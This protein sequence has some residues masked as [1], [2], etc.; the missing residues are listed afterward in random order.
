MDDDLAA[1]RYPSTPDAETSSFT[2]DFGGAPIPIFLNRT[3]SVM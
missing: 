2:G 1:D 3:A